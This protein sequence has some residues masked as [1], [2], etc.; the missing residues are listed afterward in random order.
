MEEQ[1]YAVPDNWRWVKMGSICQF[2][3]GITFPK[4]AKEKEPSEENIPCLRTTNVQEE[5]FIDDLIYVDKQYMKNNPAKLIRA[6]DIIMSSANSRELV[7]K[8][9]YINELPFPMT[10]GGF[11]LNIRAKDIISEYLFYFLRHEFLFGNFKRLATQTVN[12]ANI[13]TTKLS[14]YFIPVPPT[15]EQNKIVKNIRSLFEKLDKAKKLLQNIVD[16]YEMRRS[17][18]LHKAFD[19]PYVNMMERKLFYQMFVKLILKK[20]LLKICQMI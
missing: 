8:T 16:N 19:I 6:N 15:E 3:R 10:F 5:L 14:N 17:V 1:P 18:I 20:Y 13:N 2:E 7:G 11:V 9:C 12:I 4:K